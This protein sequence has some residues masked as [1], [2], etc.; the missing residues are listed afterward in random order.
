MRIVIVGNGPGGVELANQLS[1]EHKVTIVE[2][3]NVLHYSKPMLSH[4]IAGFV[5]KEKLF[6]YSFSW[7]EKKG[8]DLNLGVK[9]EVIDRARKRLITSDGEIPY[10][11]LVIATGAR[12]RGPTFEGKEFVQTLRTL[13]DAERIK[14]QIEKYK[15]ALILGGGFIG[16]ELVANLAKA[17]Y[18]VR[19]VHRGSN[20]LGLDEEL[21]KAIMEKLEGYGVEFYL[22]ANTLKADENGIFTDKGYVEGKVK[23]CAFGV[24][25]NKEIA[26]KGG[27]HAGRGILID[28]HFRTSAKDVYAIGDCAEYNGIIGGTAKA[29][30]EHARVLANILRGKEDSYDFEFRST[31][32]KFGDIPVALIGK[33][34]GE[35]KW[36]DEKTKIFLEGEKVIGAVVIEDVRKAMM[37]E[38]KAKAGV[39]IDEL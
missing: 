18:R 38:K 39:S 7:Y 21:T 26:V 6:P 15:D 5:E 28:D 35:G 4:Y 19:L 32:F 17:G 20:L 24:I 25:P 8:I 9:A 10:D 13:Q 36:F 14:E 23:I 1:G 27:I 31:V 22:D 12:P 16:L 34:K 11:V 29:A 3:E 30:M 33:T 37:L 2:R